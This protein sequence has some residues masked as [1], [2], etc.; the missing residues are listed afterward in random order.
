MSIDLGVLLDGFFGDAAVTVPV[1]RI[2]EGAADLLRVTEESLHRGSPDAAGRRGSRT[3]LRGAGARGG[4][5]LFGRSRVR[6]ARHRRAM[7]EEPQIPNYGEPGRGPRLAEGM[8]LA[9]EPMVNMGKAGGKVLGDGWT[10]VTRDGGLSAHFEHTV[11]VTAEGTAR[12]TAQAAPCWRAR[13]A[14]GTHRARSRLA[15]TPRACDTKRR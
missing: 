10:A 6:R 11:A 8:V 7:H 3:W 14:T 13:M 2:T 15:C 4:A 5:R 12:V 1:G 9:I